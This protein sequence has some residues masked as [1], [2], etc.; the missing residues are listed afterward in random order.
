MFSSGVTQ[1]YPGHVVGLALPQIIRYRGHLLRKQSRLVQLRQRVEDTI[2]ACFCSLF[3][4][5]WVKEWRAHPVFPLFRPGPVHAEFGQR[6]LLE[7]LA[8]RK[9]DEG[10]A[11][12]QDA[13][14]DSERW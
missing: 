9:F 2:T 4:A 12:N 7:A 13:A 5:R 8:L 14:A 11:R 3:S 1:S 6:F 10:G